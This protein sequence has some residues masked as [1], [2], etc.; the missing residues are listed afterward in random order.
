MDREQSMIFRCAFLLILCLIECSIAIDFRKYRIL[1][2][3][4]EYFFEMVN[5]TYYSRGIRKIKNYK[6]RDIIFDIYS[7]PL[8]ENKY[9]IYVRRECK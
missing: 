2:F 4:N 3:A 9:F 6:E 7:V 8:E 1:D 5:N